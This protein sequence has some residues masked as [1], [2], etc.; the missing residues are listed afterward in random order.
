MRLGWPYA[1]VII[2]LYF[3]GLLRCVFSFFLQS[4]WT[5]WQLRSEK[6]TRNKLIEADMNGK[7]QSGL[8]TKYVSFFFVEKKLHRESWETSFTC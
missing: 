7:P 8:F 2:G 6:E 4:S 3:G 1:V 5:F